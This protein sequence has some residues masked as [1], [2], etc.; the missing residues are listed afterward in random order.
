ML[1]NYFKLYSW[2]FYLIIILNIGILNINTNVTYYTMAIS[3]IISIFLFLIYLFQKKTITTNKWVYIYIIAVLILYFI[4]LIRV[5]AAF[6]K[7]MPIKQAI[8]MYD[9]VLLLLT[10]F[11]LSIIFQEKK[12]RLPF[13]KG[14]AVL[15]YVVLI[16]KLSMWILLNKY[17]INLA[18]ALFVGGETWTREFDGISFVRLGSTFLDGYLLFYSFNALFSKKKKL[19]NVISIL[20][21]IFYIVV[22]TQSRSAIIVFLLSLLSLIFIRSIKYHNLVL[23][24]SVLIIMC[25]I[26][27]WQKKYLISLIITFST[28]DATYGISTQIRLNGLQYFHQLWQNNKLLGIGFLPEIVNSGYYTKLY[29]SDYNNIINLYQFGIIG[30]F[31]LF[32]P[33][34]K[35]AIISFKSLISIKNPSFIVYIQIGLTVYLWINSISSNIYWFQMITMLP[36]Y[37]AI[38]MYV[39][40][41]IQVDKEMVK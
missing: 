36:L 16:Y 4:E 3:C 1:I 31:I 29:L 18:P 21:L 34:I 40:R 38:T 7:V 28:N 15:G 14:I 2:A 26:I 39:E 32:I 41:R 33:Y 12:Y 37:I 23:D 6:F 24:I 17:G 10:I 35:G 27:I 9:G 5:D 22:V 11:P 20:F 8:Q 19:L 25:L 13:L 30:F